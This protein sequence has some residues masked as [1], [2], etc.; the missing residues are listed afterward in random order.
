MTSETSVL[1]TDFSE[2]GTR[3]I[4]L[5]FLHVGWS[6]EEYLQAQVFEIAYMYLLLSHNYK[7]QHWMHVK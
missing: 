5:F 6:V 2:I 3:L 1:L 4:Q 7:W